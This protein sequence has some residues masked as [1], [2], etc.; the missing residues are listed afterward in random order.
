MENKQT[1]FVK[2]SNKIMFKGSTEGLD[3][4]LEP[5]KV[6]TIK[7][8]RYTD[9]LSLE[10]ST[11]LLTPDK[12]YSTEKEDSFIDKVMSRYKNM[13]NGVLGVMLEGIKGSGKTIMAKQIANRSNL[14]III[15]D[16]KFHPSYFRKLFNLMND[17]E[18]CFVFDEID[19]INNN[20]G[21]YDDTFLLTALDGIDTSGKKL[22]LFTC[23][24]SCSIN[25]FMKDRCSRI[26]YWL[27]F[28]E[29]S[30]NMIQ[31]ILQDK[32]KNSNNIKNVTDFILKNFKYA[33]FDN[34]IAFVDEINENPKSTLNELFDDMNLSKK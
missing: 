24:N 10:L 21:S 33:T 11:D 28:K 29:L 14:P 25:E 23:N 7:T 4:N 3:Y 30:C 31:T 17:T 5:S 6:Y 19:K 9:E 1:N 27:N 15:V 26:R 34:I 16:K 12:I 2:I 20:S 8:D 13:K 22:I 18:A 32:L